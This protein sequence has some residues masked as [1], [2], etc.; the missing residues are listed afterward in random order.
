MFLNTI[1]IQALWFAGDWSR[2]FFIIPPSGLASSFPA[3]RN[4]SKRVSM[5]A[6]F[7]PDYYTASPRH[8]RPKYLI[9]DYTPGR[10][11]KIT[12]FQRGHVWDLYVWINSNFNTNVDTN[13]N[14]S[15]SKFKRSWGHMCNYCWKMLLN[16]KLLEFV[17]QHLHV[18]RFS[19]LNKIAS[20]KNQSHRFN[21]ATYAC[22]LTCSGAFD[23]CRCTFNVEKYIGKLPPELRDFAHIPPT[24]H[25]LCSFLRLIDWLLIWLR[26]T[27]F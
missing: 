20:T 3:Y 17:Q 4:F 16:K 13:S 12:A 6:Y 27:V 24:A 25:H 5:S 9:R 2:H 22:L 14:D 23:W 10:K 1:L 19:K 8:P 15:C 26:E 11:L 7:P 18:K 21:A